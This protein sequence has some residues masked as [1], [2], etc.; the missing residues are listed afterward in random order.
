[1]LHLQAFPPQEILEKSFL[2]DLH[3]HSKYSRASSKGMEPKTLYEVGRQKGLEVIGTGDFT[4]PQYLKELK[5]LLEFNPSSGLY[6]LREKGPSPP[7][8]VPTAEIS[9]IY[10]TK[11]LA[12]RRIHL[13]LIAPNLAIVEEVNK[14][15]SKIG[16]LLADG[17][18]TFGL[19]AEKLV[20]DLRSISSEILV[21]P[22]HAWTPWYSVFG[23]FSGFNSL[24]EAFGE[25]TPFIYAIETGLSSDPEMNWR[26]SALDKISLISNSDAHSPSKIG[27]E[28]TAFFYPLSFTSIYQGI[29]EGLIAYTIEFY[30]EEGKY[31]YDGHRTCGVVLHP[32]ETKKLHHRCPKCGGPLTIGVLHRIEDLAD[33]EEGIIPPGKP[34]SVHVVPLIEILAEIYGLNPTSKSLEKI[35]RLT[36]ERAGSEF[37]I[38]I[39]RELKDLEEVLE[40]SLSK[41]L[42]RMRKGEVYLQPGY[43]GVYGK[44]SVFPREEEIKTS[45][46]KGQQSLFS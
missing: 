31:H 26:I 17:R 28:A 29:K 41:A 12:N 30:P 40:E 23:A 2:A 25:A 32:K 3:I 45:T 22:A 13:I 19:T 6:F 9:L 42:A 33:R 1:M 18:P 38:L 7:F 4:H 10:S 8:F 35:Y 24:E 44:V 43:D 21:I 15:L 36:L 39:K 14:Y 20:L 5:E 34:Y 46:F 27:R 11:H 37:D 16:N